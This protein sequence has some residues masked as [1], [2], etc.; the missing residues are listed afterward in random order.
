MSDT[1]IIEKY[2]TRTYTNDSIAVYLYAAGQN[3]SKDNAMQT[4][5]DDALT[6]FWPA[7]RKPL[8][9][10]VVR[11][12]FETKREL[13]RKGKIKVKPIYEC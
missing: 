1:I 4:V 8:V 2:L 5:M 7:M 9:T 13:F 6:V 11:N 10:K 12:Y 3:R